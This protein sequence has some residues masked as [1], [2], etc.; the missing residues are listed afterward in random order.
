MPRF[1]VVALQEASQTIAPEPDIFLAHGSQQDA[2]AAAT[3]MLAAF[4]TRAHVT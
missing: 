1:K 3:A 2:G 4:L